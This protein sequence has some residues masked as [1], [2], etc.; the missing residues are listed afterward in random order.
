MEGELEPV[1]SKQNHFGKAIVYARYESVVEERL[2]EFM[3]RA[4]EFQC[5]LADIP[6]VGEPIVPGSPVATI[7]A[8]GATLADV[9][10]R[11]RGAAEKMYRILTPP[12]ASSRN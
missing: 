7:L 3:S 9:E 4:N 8:Q 5:S 10:R 11:L 2:S 6:A 12:T 1:E